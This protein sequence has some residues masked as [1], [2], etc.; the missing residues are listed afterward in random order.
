MDGGHDV[1]D[2][3]DLPVAGAGEPVADLVAGYGPVRW[4]NA[5]L[6]AA[7]RAILDAHP[8]RRVVEVTLLQLRALLG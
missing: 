4:S 7:V 8:N 5:T 1:Q 2:P 3:V 6:T